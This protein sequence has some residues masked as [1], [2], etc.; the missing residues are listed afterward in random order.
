MPQFGDPATYRFSS[1]N[2]AIGL[3]I[4]IIGLAKKCLFADPIST[5]VAQGFTD[6][7]HLPLFAA[8]NV[9]LCYSLQL[10]F[11]FS[12]YSDMA[13]GLARMFNIR[14]PLNFNSP[15]KATSIIDHWQRW[16]I[17][18][19]RYLA[20]YLYNPIALAVTRWRDKRG[21]EI[22]RK[23][24]ARLPGFST[25]VMFPTL[26][27]MGLAGIWHGAGFQFL[28]FGLLHGTYL[29]VN[30][31]LRIFWP[32]PPHAPPD[33]FFT[34]R[35]KVLFTYLTVLIASVF[36]R[37]PSVSS[38]LALLTG[39]TGLHGLDSLGVPVALL[40][41]LGTV[42][43]DLVARGTAVIVSPGDFLANVIHI[44][45][46]VCLYAIVWTLPNTQQIMYR[47][48]PAIGR[49]HPAPSQR[50][51][52]QPSRGWAVAMGVAACVS[53]LAIGGTSEFLYFKF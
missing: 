37:A 4:F 12:G 53:V 5:V 16:H 39:M 20:L 1:E 32:R 28:V 38:A 11:D 19:S 46:I 27:T 29:T 33:G 18:L 36:F 40:G 41:H 13:I 43:E 35:G 9:A 8:W 10:Y 6:P 47:F 7:G 51:V 44:F 23:A 42:G 48:A 21:F 50:L 34:H 30:H 25:M 22:G 15:Y 52:W 14:F 17:T 2:M 3:S 26:V 49:I 24:Q 45:W 31:A